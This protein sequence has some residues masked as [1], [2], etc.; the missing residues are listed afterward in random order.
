MMHVLLP[1]CMSLPSEGGQSSLSW[2]VHLF[3][4]YFHAGPQ[5]PLLSAYSDILPN[6]MKSWHL[7]CF[8]HLLILKSEILDWG[9]YRRKR[10]RWALKSPCF[11]AGTFFDF[12][13]TICSLILC[14]LPSGT[15]VQR[16]QNL[17]NRAFR[18]HVHLAIENLDNSGSSLPKKWEGSNGI[19]K[20][21]HLFLAVLG[22]C[23]CVWAFLVAVYWLLSCCGTRT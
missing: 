10:K 13:P 1:R 21:L 17:K 2:P 20:F 16:K 5:R 3:C 4:T 22:L 11:P 14:K 19:F 18:H 8:P 15:L 7:H 9:K 6:T 23:C 12:F